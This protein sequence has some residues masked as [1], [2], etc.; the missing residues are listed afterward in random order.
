MKYLY[1]CDE[2]SIG[3]LSLRAHVS[4][5]LHLHLHLQPLVKYNSSMYSTPIII[6]IIVLC[7]IAVHTY[8]E[9]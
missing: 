4:I 6:V 1:D 2:R 7:A 5:H 9:I 8:T 3:L